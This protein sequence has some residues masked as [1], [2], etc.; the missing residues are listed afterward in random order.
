MNRR[1]A[2]TLIEL[3]VVIAIIAILA[4]ILFPVFAQAK[5]AA[6]KSAMLSNLKQNATA[7]LLYNADHDGTFAQSAYS[8][9]TPNGIVMPGA[10]VY[11]V[12]DALQPYSKNND[13]LTAPGDE[14]SIKW[15]TILAAIGMTPAEKITKASFAFNFAIF[16][17]PAVPPT[18][19][20]ADPVV[21]EGSIGDVS[22][23]PMF[24][25]SKYIAAGQTNP[26]VPAANDPNF[27]YRPNYRVPAGPLD[28]TN[29]AGYPRYSKG[30]GINFA[31]SHAKWYKADAFLGGTAPDLQQASQPIIRCFDLPYDL[32][33]IPDMVAE[34]K[35]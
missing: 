3:L 32:N 14:S 21:G 1:T 22:G 13:I 25:E 30:I 17:D 10:K 24:F 28:R 15:Q 2:F 7:V 19:G 33:G 4:A 9:N 35:P 29:F 20:A 26:Y 5:E 11:A 18:M 27:P 31:D 16:E 34:P 8:I 23:T 12:F 6:K